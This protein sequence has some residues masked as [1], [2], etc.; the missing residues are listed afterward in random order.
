M[1]HELVNG[2]NYNIIHCIFAL[3]HVQPKLRWINDEGRPVIKHGKRGAWEPILVVSIVFGV[4][5][6]FGAC[7]LFLGGRGS[8]CGGW[9]AYPNAFP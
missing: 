3:A 9:L 8:R 1:L 7:L 6:F 2:W 4:E 5:E